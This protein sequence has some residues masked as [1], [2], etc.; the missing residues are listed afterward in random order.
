MR[1]S[2]IDPAA[3]LG[4]VV[5]TFALLLIAMPVVDV[6][7]N[8]WPP[9]FGLADWRYGMIGISANYIQTPILG[10]VMAGLTAYWQDHRTTLRALGIVCL[11]AGAV[12]ALA[13]LTFSLDV[14]QV[15]QAVV[16]DAV[17]RFKTGAVKA[18]FKLGTAA[19][20]LVFL[21]HALWH[22][23]AP[24][25]GTLAEASPA[26]VDWRKQGHSGRPA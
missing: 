9:N 5:Y 22:A 1:T 6:A 23:G 12:V 11:A 7:T 13:L 24:D 16:G 2:H 3:R 21:A 10:L 19:T 8:L 15:R 14:V 4:W 26:D 18:T 25:S 17:A 20:F